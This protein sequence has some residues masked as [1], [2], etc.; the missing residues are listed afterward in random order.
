MRTELRMA[1]RLF[2]IATLAGGDGLGE[3]ARAQDRTGA[4]AYNACRLLTSSE[5]NS[6]TEKD[7]IMA[8]VEEAAPERS[9][10]LWED[11]TGLVFKLTVYWTG[12]KQGWETWRA[13]HRMGGAVLNEAERVEPDSI[14]KQGLVP[15]LGDAAYFSELLPSLLLKGDALAEME[16]SLVPHPRGSSASS[17]RRCSLAC[18]PCPARGVESGG[19]KG[20]R[21][22]YLSHPMPATGE[23]DVTAD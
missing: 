19:G 17:R 13:S 10:C 20:E 6:L 5:I 14:I 11:A 9:I 22:F 1:L 21:E 15:G 7:V 2:A 4:N 3:A 16:M 8:E 12:G 23:S 18:D